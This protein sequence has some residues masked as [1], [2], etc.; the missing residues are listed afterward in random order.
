M[1]SN[2]LIPEDIETDVR[3][4]AS[5]MAELDRVLLAA[6]VNLDGDAL[7]SL[8]AAGWIYKALGKKFAIYCPNGVPA[9]LDFVNLPGAIYTSLD[10]LPFEPET[11]LYLDC[12]AKN[13]LGREL[14]ERSD[15]LP[16]VNID[17]HMTERGLGTL[18]NLIVPHAAATCQLMAYVSLALNFKLEEPLSACLALGLMTDTGWFSHGNTSAEVLALCSLIVKNGF[19]LE[20]LREQLHNNWAL[21][22]MRLWG[23]LLSEVTLYGDRKIA[24]AAVSGEELRRYHCGKD[25]L[26]GL[27]EWFRRL[28]GVEVAAIL[29]EES[30]NKCKFSLRS[31]GE[32][33]VHSI[34]EAL[35]GGGHL[36]ASGGSIELPLEEAKVVL[37]ETIEKNLRLL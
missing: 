30:E 22:K 11:A 19:S 17:H 27:V 16:S 7:G 33:D 37:L 3:T 35:N 21:G 1:S 6:H 29:R 28:R 2:N 13:R 34:A 12:S 25:D 8:G 4:A 15:A 14:E 10:S 24:F 20:K 23:R 18:A 31:R 32:V 36:H 26:E 5:A 9:Y